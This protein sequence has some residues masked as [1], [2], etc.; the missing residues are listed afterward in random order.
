MAVRFD[1]GSLPP[2]DRAEAI[3]EVSR[4]LNGRSEV[5]FP[6]NPDRIRAV[7]T[8]SAL[9]SVEI[10]NIHWNVAAL[11]R[12]A[13]PMTDDVEP[14]VL[15]G[16]QKSGVSRFAQDGRQ[17]EIR[18]GDL[19]LLQNVN[20]YSVFFQDTVTTLTVR[21]PNHLLGLP[22]SMLGRI[23]SVRLG[24]ERPVVDTAAAFISRLARN[25]AAIG[26]TDAG[27]LAQPCIELIRAVVTTGLGHDD[28]AR[29]PLHHTLLQR[30]MTYIRRHL[31]ERDLSAERIAAEHHISVRQLY[32]ILSQAGISLGDWVRSQRLEKCKL[33][34]ASPAHRFTT[35]EAIAYRWGFASA[36]HFSRVFKAAYGVS[37]R[38][39][40]HGN[41]RLPAGTERQ[42]EQRDSRTR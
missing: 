19:V 18:P 34:L 21:V 14:H 10:S 2:N 6:S 27:L 40:R 12:T 33:E 24:L 26:E 22:P 39:W 28:L 7:T 9:G 35:I 42:P 30:V 11:R 15:V 41:R 17:A 5:D 25:Q 8:T 1:V 38:E 3:R 31:A 4:T 37:P 23:T 16:L 20:P 32:L 13:G 29:E 36:P